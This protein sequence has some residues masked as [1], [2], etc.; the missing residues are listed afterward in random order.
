MFVVILLLNVRTV[1]SG[2]S[3]IEELSDDAGVVNWN[4]DPPV[5]IKAS[6][7]VLICTSFLGCLSTKIYK[8]LLW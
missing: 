3:L 5:V 7:T 6:L 4:S 8:S 1:V 2:S